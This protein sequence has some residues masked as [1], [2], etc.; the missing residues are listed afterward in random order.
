MLKFKPSMDPESR[1]I[2]RDDAEIG[3]LQW[4]KDR[5]PRVR[6]TRTDELTIGEMREIIDKFEEIRKS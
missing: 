6:L 2:L 5:A 1:E 4:H 3:Y